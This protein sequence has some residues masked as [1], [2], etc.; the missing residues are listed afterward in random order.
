M[1]IT[2]QG[3]RE[4]SKNTI[5]FVRL[6]QNSI[7]R[8]TR[9]LQIQSKI[10]TRKDQNHIDTEKLVDSLR[11]PC[12]QP[13]GKNSKSPGPSSTLIARGKTFSAKSGTSSTIFSAEKTSSL[14]VFGEIIS[15][16][17]TEASEV[18]ESFGKQQLF[19]NKEVCGGLN[20]TVL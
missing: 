5:L 11:I 10:T 2:I 14:D 13:G 16:D 1:G 17:T 15:S 6:H 20:Q 9:N 3:K 4:R 12:H 8:I 19:I 7:F 18:R